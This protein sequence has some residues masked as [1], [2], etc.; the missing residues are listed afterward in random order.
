LVRWDA[1]A[2]VCALGNVRWRSSVAGNE[3]HV[4]I[5]WW[6]IAADRAKNGLA[7]RVPLSPPVFKIL[8]GR[9]LQA[10]GSPFVFPGARPNHPVTTI[11]K[12]STGFARRPRWTSAFT[13]FA[14]RQPAT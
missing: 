2:I 5:G 1:V 7:Q 8:E 13:I 12:P 3:V 4:S 9:R 11:Q 14:A 10:A 6:V